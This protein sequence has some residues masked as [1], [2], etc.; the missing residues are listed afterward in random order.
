MPIQER[1]YNPYSSIYVASSTLGGREG[2]WHNILLNN[3][4]CTGAILGKPSA[5]FERLPMSLK[6]EHS[7]FD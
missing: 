6:G 4:G 1:S 2:T 3:V 7:L 5:E